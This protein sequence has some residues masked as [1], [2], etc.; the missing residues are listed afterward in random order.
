VDA[1]P[2]ELVPVPP[3]WLVEHGVNPW[4]GPRSLPLWAPGPEY[5]GFMAHDVSASLAA[6]LR[7]RPIEESAAA[8][9]RHERA[10]GLDRERKAG[11]TAGEE[12][13]LLAAYRSDRSG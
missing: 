6:G 2:H 5:A 11:L 12:A 4:S 8:A 3:S 13:E 10:L 7:T 1:P 9:L